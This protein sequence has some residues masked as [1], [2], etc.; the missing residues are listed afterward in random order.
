[1]T[2]SLLLFFTLSALMSILLAVVVILP[3]LKNQVIAQDNQLMALNVQ[4]F[5][6]RIAELESDRVS[7]LI[8]EVGFNQQKLDLQRQLLAAKDHIATHAPVGYRSRVIV[9]IWIPMLVA[10][11]YLTTSDRTSVFK[12]WHAQNQVG[13]VADDLL[14]AKIDAPPQ[15]ATTDSAA[16]ISAMQTNV[17]HHAYDA[18]RWMRL[19][20]LFIAL[21]AKPQAIEALA[22]AYRLDP[23]NIDI[24][25]AYAQTQFFNNSGV[26]DD[27]IRTILKN[28]LISTPN[29]EGAQ[30]L[31]AMGE[32]RAG[33]YTMAKAWVAKLR[34]SIAA[35]SGDGS[36]AL[37]SLDEL[38]ASID[39]QEAATKATAAQA[40]RVTVNIS[41]IILPDI[42]EQDVLFVS[43]SDITGGAPYAVRRMAASAIR[44][45]QVI[46]DLS[47]LHAMMPERTLSS[48]RVAG[49]DLVVNARISPTGNAITST[50][51]MIAS[52]VILG[53]DDKAVS[54]SI[55]KIA[56]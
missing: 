7:G 15:W 36:S 1:M 44:Q 26:L 43:I 13:Q 30:M 10:L 55:D 49:V 16:L 53:V 19:S 42:S 14:T 56:P 3:W 41:D 22:R 35:R 45:G 39:A 48:A 24:A 8:D 27:N 4:V 34:S 31:M 6:E 17:H 54:L 18:D 20:E 25:M 11:V 50:G 46:V 21:D 2:P 9:L 12:L 23:D 40:V 5:E 33:N 29:H 38:A 32:T 52:P 51:D 37:A 28:V 47:D